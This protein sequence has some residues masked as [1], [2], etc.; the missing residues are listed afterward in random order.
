MDATGEPSVAVRRLGQA[1]PTPDELLLLKA[2]AL[3]VDAATA[4]WRRWIAN[5][6]VQTAHHRS[7]ALLPVVAANLPADVLGTHAALAKGMRRRVWLENQL[8]FGMLANAVEVL[9]AAGIDTVV[10]KGAA[11]ATT[12]YADVG[13]RPMA[14][15]DLIV[16]PEEFAR[17]RALLLGA[18]WQLLH[19]RD[20]TDID[21]AVALVDHNGRQIDLHRWVLFPRFTRH[22]ERSWHARA[23][24]HRVN[25]QPTR[26][27]AA[28]DELVLGVVHGLLNSA[29]ATRWPLDVVQ[30]CRAHADDPSFWPMVVGAATESRTGPLLADG[31]R[32]CR[33]ELDV[34]VPA[35]VVADLEAAP[36]DRWLRLQSRL[37][38][39]GFDLE[40]RILRYA[41]IAAANG[42]R[43]TVRG[44][45]G[46]RWR[47]LRAR[48]VGP[49]LGGRLAR[50]RAARAARAAR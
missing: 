36:L 48:G 42:G 3:D 37:R 45:L 20:F 32:M 11:L 27:F 18:G 35:G 49:V 2:A 38:R 22:P 33:D 15:V 46:P 26:R 24:P 19:G 8:G 5:N 23:V 40:W 39:R 47:T 13:T 6:D 10:T 14:D 16:E 41:R 30:L 12:V 1:G 43:P 9:T 50:L 34:A 25:G 7:T 4:A 28:S 31:L 29:S 17:S 21:H 44:Y